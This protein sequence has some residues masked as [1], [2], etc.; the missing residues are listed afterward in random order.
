M[1]MELSCARSFGVSRPKRLQSPGSWFDTECAVRTTEVQ[2]IRVLSTRH[3]LLRGHGIS[4]CEDG[5]YGIKQ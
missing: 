2:Q 4:T 3:E 5:I 1:Q